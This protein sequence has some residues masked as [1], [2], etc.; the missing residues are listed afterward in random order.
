M[1][2]EF[3]LLRLAR[4]LWLS[5]KSLRGV[6]NIPTNAFSLSRKNL[7]TRYG[8]L[9]DRNPSECKR[10]SSAA[11]HGRYSDQCA[12]NSVSGPLEKAIYASCP[13]SSQMP[14][15]WRTTRFLQGVNTT[16]KITACL[17]FNPLP[18]ALFLLQQ[19]PSS[20]W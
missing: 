4:S 11:E 8:E 15:T 7:T 18:N 6:T 3:S 20:S 12:V 14:A 10:A 1:P 17:Y 9:A 19:Y 16:Q 13:A 5:L 2:D